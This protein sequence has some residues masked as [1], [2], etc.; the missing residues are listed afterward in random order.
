MKIAREGIPFIAAFLGAG[1]VLALLAG[2]LSG[3]LVWLFGAGSAIFLGLGIFSLWFFRDPERVIPDGPGI[4]VSPADGTVVAVTED[5][6][7]PSVAI[8]LSV[9]NVHV[10]RSPIAGRVTDVSYR[11]GRFLAAFDERA[12]EMNERSEILVMGE[13]GAVRVRQ[14]AGVLAR[15][16]ICKVKPGDR[17]SAGERFG[18]IRFGSRT[19]L[20]MPPGSTVAVKVGDKVQGGASV[21]GRMAPAAAQTP[22]ALAGTASA[23]RGDRA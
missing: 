1:I 22:A 7:G 5:P 17:L 18:L 6:E 19:D 9:L 10:N 14:I 11:K 21:I 8:F 2:A 15:R 4:V 13:D 3:A 23:L 20:R 12:G 16:I